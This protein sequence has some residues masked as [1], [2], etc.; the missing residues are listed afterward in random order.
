MWSVNKLQL[1]LSDSRCKG[2]KDVAPL[3][4]PGDKRLKKGQKKTKRE[5]KTLDFV[6]KTYKKGCPNGQPC[7]LKVFGF[8]CSHFVY[9]LFS[10]NSNIRVTITKDSGQPFQSQ[11]TYLDSF[12]RFKEPVMRPTKKVRNYKSLTSS[13]VKPVMSDIIS[14]AKP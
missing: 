4:K 9:K 8:I 13:I 10:T 1:Y 14:N 7:T 2:M 6:P 5:T 11:E 3:S 12:Q